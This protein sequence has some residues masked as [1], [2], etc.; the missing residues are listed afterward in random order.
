MCRY[1][2]AMTTTTTQSVLH[3]ETET[4]NVNANQKGGQSMNYLYATFGD[5]AMP[6]A[7]ALAERLNRKANGKGVAA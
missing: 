7:E 6:K 4:A 5:E 3:K 1:G 2:T